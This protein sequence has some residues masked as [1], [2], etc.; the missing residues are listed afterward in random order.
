LI[1]CHRLRLL[2]K[3]KGIAKIDAA[4]ERTSVQFVKHPPFDPASLVTMIRNDGRLRFAGP[5]RIRI[6]RAAPTLADARGTGQG[7]RREARMSAAGEAQARRARRRTIAHAAGQ[8][9]RNLHL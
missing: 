8:P 5:D 3:S 1:A 2:A 7:I 6:D 9:E 4:A